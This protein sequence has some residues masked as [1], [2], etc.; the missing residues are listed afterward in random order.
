MEIKK[1]KIVDL[2][3]RR[4]T[5]LLL[6]LIISFGVT[7][8]SFEWLKS[9]IVLRPISSLESEDLYEPIHE[10]M[11]VKPMPKKQIF[12]QPKRATKGPVVVKNEPTIKPKDPVIALKKK[13]EPNPNSSFNLDATAPETGEP[14]REP[15]INIET[16]PYVTVEQKPEFEG[17]PQ[18]MM[19]FISKNIVYP[20]IPRDNGKQGKVYV[21]FIIDKEG[22]VTNV[23]IVR[24]VEKHLDKEAIRVIKKMPKWKPG[25]QRGIPVKVK[26]TIPVNYTLKG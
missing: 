10:V 18:E 24:G 11:I 1:S 19:R 17:G 14:T 23:E 25:K 9:D 3:N 5:L 8:E 4:P 22:N 20:S 2:E 15:V 16:L 13:L 12:N 21:S 6:G 26:Y 7:L